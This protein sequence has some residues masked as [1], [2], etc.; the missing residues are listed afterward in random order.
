MSIL[1]RQREVKKNEKAAR[2]RAKRLGQTIEGA[3]EPRPTEGI[4]ALFSANPPDLSAPI[5]DDRPEESADD[6]EKA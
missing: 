6:D 1:K 3:A 4:A 2:K 5:P